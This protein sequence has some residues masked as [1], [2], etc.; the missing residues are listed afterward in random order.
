MS[1][2]ETEKG[3]NLWVLQFCHSYDGPLVDCARQYT[4]LFVGT[5]YKVCTVYLTGKPNADVETDSTSDQVI[6]LDYSSR[7]VRGLKIKAIHDFKRI[8]ASRNFSLCIAHRFKLIYIALLGSELPV[9]GVQHGLGVY[10]K[11]SRQIFARIFRAR[12]TLLGVSDAIRDDMRACLQS[13]PAERI[14]TLYSRIDVEVVQAQQLSR[15]AARELLGVQQDTYVVGNV[16]RLHPDTDQAT[17]IRGFAQAF[18]QLPAGSLLT[19]MGSGRLESS[20][21]GLA[22]ELGIADRVR[23][24]G[25]VPNGHRYFKAFDVFALTCD[26]EPFGMLLLEAMAAGVPVICTDCGNGREFVQEIGRMIPL[27]NV[28]LL[29]A[30]LVQQALSSPAELLRLRERMNENLQLRFSERAVRR[31]FWSLHGL[32]SEATTLG[33][34][35]ASANVWRA[36]AKALDR[37][38]WLLLRE[39]HGVVGSASRFLR[40]A[41]ADWWFG[42]HAKRQLAST[43]DAEPCDFLLLQ[44]APK[45]IRLQRKKLL[46]EALRS[47]GYNLIET[48]LPIPRDICANRLLKS[49]PYP[50][51]QRYF[52]YAAH[53]MWVVERYQ[54]HVLLN[55][56][57][58]SLYSPFLRLALATRQCPLVHLAHATT[59]EGSRRLSMNDYDYYLLFG[60]SSLQALQGR[61]LRFGTSTT[62]L[63][64]SHMIDQ[65][66]DLPAADPFVRSM[67]ILGVGPDKEKESGY[68]RTYGLLRDWAREHSQ[69]RVL[70]KSHPRSSVPFWQEAEKTLANV[71]VISSACP[72]AQALEQASLV[73]NIMSNAVIEAAL[74]AR[75]VIYCNLSE[76]C[77]VFAQE[78][79]FGLAITSPAELQSRVLAIEKD[80]SSYVEKARAFGAFHLAH[81]SDGLVKT[82]QALQCL[83][84]GMALPEDIKKAV[85]PHCGIG[86]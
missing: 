14:Q 30:A 55:D 69:Y 85:L 20:L 59:V 51:P 81:G 11:R 64:G 76:D 31:Q 58:G 37:Y 84:Q 17:L 86:L 74:A 32:S 75:P 38:R 53:A 71:K 16:G 68:Q 42:I 10:K 73:V 41:V 48:A 78:R 1:T 52:G 83:R 47:R 21:K 13:W 61:K 79:F 70:V 39:R 62:A 56:R 80:F 4:A 35:K 36:K 82:V 7:E 9:V 46:I 3:R 8:A 65:S 27:G 29:A 22:A 19:I 26:C 45:V 50:M 77:D 40:D 33:I 63:T 15:E 43:V 67:L 72:L 44:S 49:P 5:S 18:A 24:L 2:G 28:D 23:F 6:F 57:N 12:L 25:Q 34:H 54:P 60:P 66:Y